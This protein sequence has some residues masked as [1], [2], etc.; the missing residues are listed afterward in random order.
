MDKTPLG[1][2]LVAV[3]ALIAQVMLVNLLIAMMGDTYSNVQANSTRVL[4][5]STRIEL[6]Y[7]GR[8]SGNSTGW[9]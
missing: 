1:I 7:N 3:Y 5:F 2:A 9:N 8:R 4:L 6:S